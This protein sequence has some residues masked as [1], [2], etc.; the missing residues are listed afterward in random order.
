LNVK[1]VGESKTHGIIDLLQCAKPLIFENDGDKFHF[2]AH[3]T[4]FLVQF[5]SHY[6]AITAKHCLK[7]FPYES[8]RIRINPG[9]LEFLVLKNLTLPK[10]TGSDFSDLAFFEVQHERL[11][12]AVLNSTHFLHLD[13]YAERE[14]DESEILAIVG[15]PSELNTVDY[16]NV[17]VRTQGFSTDGRYAG[18]GEDRFC[19]KIRFN[20]L[21]A[22]S[23]LDGLSGSPVLAFK[24]IKDAVY[25]HRF[26]GVLIRGTKVSG[27]GRYINS[28]VVIHALKYLSATSYL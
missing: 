23:D 13:N 21:E 11:P 19:S 15:H 25:T 5:E 2:S 14:V 7:N 9:E 28:A 26:V 24:E 6:Y 12:T 3:G 8:V 27:I 4:C 10:E 18:P 20:K 22:I 16:E 17:I 1:N